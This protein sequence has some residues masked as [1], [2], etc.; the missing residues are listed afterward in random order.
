VPV[1]KLLL[2]NPK[3]RKPDVFWQNLL[4]KTGPKRAVLLLLMIFIA[5]IK[6]YCDLLQDCLVSC[7]IGSM[8]G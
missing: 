3:K 6:P 4:R 7:V 8:R 2:Q 5:W 1:K